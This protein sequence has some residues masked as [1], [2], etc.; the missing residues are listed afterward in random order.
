MFNN[1]KYKINQA[2]KEVYRL[3]DRDG[4]EEA[5]VTFDYVKPPYLG[6]I[7]KSEI[8]ICRSVKRDDLAYKLF[9]NHDDEPLMTVFGCWPER[10]VIDVFIRALEHFYDDYQH[11]GGL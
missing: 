5:T 8:R 2:V 6:Y 1:N 7:M 10:F 4:F 11:G 9:I 3:T